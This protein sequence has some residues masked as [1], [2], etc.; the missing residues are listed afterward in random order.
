M[1]SSV[2]GIPV[3]LELIEYLATPCSWTARKLG[4]LNGQL[5]IKV[6]H[7]Q[8]RRAWQGHLERTRNIIRAA[9][10]D[11]PQRRKAVVLGSGLLLDVPLSDL[12]ATFDEVVLVDVVHPL[13]VYLTA[14]WYRNVT[15]LQAD[16]TS[17]AA[18]LARA[19]RD[20]S[21]PLPHAFPQ[22]FCDDARVDY[23]VSV[24]L[25]SQ[26]PYVPSHYLEKNSRPEAEIEAYGRDLIESHLDYLRRLPGVVTL[27]TDVEK[28][29]LDRAGE[30]V[31]RYDILYGATIPWP[32][33]EWRWEHVPLGHVASDFSYHRRVCAVK[34]VKSL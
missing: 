2:E 19:A 33:D 31:D 12:S 1:S 32:A 21:I 5:G 29:K 3:I 34:N 15:L 24:N 20:A 22:L 4:Y 16:V 10:L 28:L 7:R 26:L 27:I 30:I 25:L 14:R 8:C 11:C 17:T 13:S 18:E 6:R 9:I 23:V